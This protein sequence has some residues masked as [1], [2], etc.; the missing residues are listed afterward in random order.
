MC[1]GVDAHLGSGTLL[2]GGIGAEGVVVL[3]APVLHGRVFPTCAVGIVCH[4][5]VH[6]YGGVRFVHTC[7]PSPY[8]HGAEVLA[9]VVGV[10]GDGMV[11]VTAFEADGHGT[12]VVGLCHHIVL[13]TIAYEQC[14]EQ[15]QICIPVFTHVFSLFCSFLFLV[16][17]WG[18]ST[19]L[20]LNRHR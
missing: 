4:G 17:K 2:V 12:R 15:Q 11:Y 8:A 16:A 3:L 1:I 5:L 10:A 6:E 14:A 13:H 20:G 19:P 7:T 18:H 9:Q